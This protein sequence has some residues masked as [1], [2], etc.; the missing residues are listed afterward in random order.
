MSS[1]DQQYPPGWLTRFRHGVGSG[2]VLLL[3]ALGCCAVPTYAA[4]LMPGTDSTSAL[5]ALKAAALVLLAA[6]HGG[7]VLAGVPVTLTP[8]L[9]TLGLGW[10]VGGHARRQGSRSGFAGL[11]VGYASGSA[12]LAG[13]ARL[14]STHAPVLPSLL[15]ALVFVL[16]VGGA[17]RSAGELW[18]RLPVR[19]Q[20]VS[21]AAAVVAAGY[22]AVGSLL[23]AGMLIA[24]FSD[25]VALQRQLAPGAAGLPVALLG[26]SATPNA[27]LAGVSYLTG[28]GFDIGASTS[29][30]AF[31]VSSGRLPVFP[32]LAG[33]PH[34]QP[35][36]WLAVL[37]VLAPALVA[38]WAVLRIVPATHR[39]WTD[40]LAD[41]AAAA[42]LAG[43]LLAVP[44]GLA[45]GTLGRN[46]LRHVGAHWWA[47]GLS[48]A[49]LV[50]LAAACWLGI[51][52]VRGRLA[53]RGRPGLYALKSEPAEDADQD[54]EDDG[55]RPLT[56]VAE[57]AAR[58]RTAS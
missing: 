44:T 26:I 6:G 39:P 14:G 11:A 37:T 16:A 17:A 35:A 20:Q 5:S 25:A 52:A 48:T 1:T 19:W 12:V 42:A 53:D 22:L 4:W 58:S 50:L 27:V 23:S 55:N 7:V 51:E 30:S 28:P 40:R 10:L 57:T 24:H 2:L 29:V 36:G 8:L 56:P 18:N 54:E 47:V 45:A 41:C 9:V 15:A 34:H 38:G 21:R 43:L 13:W 3:I 49:L 31:G 33:L 46:T 32:M